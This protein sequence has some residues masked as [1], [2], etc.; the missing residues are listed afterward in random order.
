MNKLNLTEFSQIFQSL[1]IRYNLCLA[2]LRLKSLWF[3][4]LLGRH[5]IGPYAFGQIP[6]ACRVLFCPMTDQLLQLLENS[7]LKNIYLPQSVLLSDA[8]IDTSKWPWV[9]NYRYEDFPVLSRNDPTAVFI[10]LLETDRHKPDFMI[11]TLL[12]EQ[13]YLL[14]LTLISFIA[15]A[16]NN[17]M[18]WDNQKNSWVLLSLQRDNPTLDDENRMMLLTSHCIHL[19]E[20]WLKH[21]AES[22]WLPQRFTRFLLKNAEA[23]NILQKEILLMIADDA[24]SHQH[25]P[26]EQLQSIR[27]EIIITFD[28]IQDIYESA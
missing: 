1:N 7:R 4:R 6:D 27:N 9:K 5:Q 10:Y 25:W 22:I 26:A 24:C 28:R 11:K 13:T 3:R 20:G 15:I 8:G 17:C 21:G 2:H 19:I 14:P 12:F 16:K 18:G 23:N